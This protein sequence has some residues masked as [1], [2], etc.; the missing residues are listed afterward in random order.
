LLFSSKMGIH[1][2]DDNSILAAVHGQKSR[3]MSSIASNSTNYIDFFWKIGKS[4][5]S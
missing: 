1:S 4:L 2:A 5:Q 3:D